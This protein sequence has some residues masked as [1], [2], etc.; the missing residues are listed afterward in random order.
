MVGEGAETPI[1]T[2]MR[3]Y[4]MFSSHTLDGIYG[5]DTSADERKINQ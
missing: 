4:K 3:P 2:G 1:H 5:T